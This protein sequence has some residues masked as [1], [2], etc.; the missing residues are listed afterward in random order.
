MWTTNTLLYTVWTWH[1]E[2]I[3]SDQYRWLLWLHTHQ[4]LLRRCQWHRWSFWNAI[5]KLSGFD[6][7]ALG[8]LYPSP[9]LSP[10]QWFLLLIVSRRRFFKILCSVFSRFFLFRHRVSPSQPLPK[11]ASIKAV[12]A[13]QPID[14]LIEYHYYQQLACTM[15]SVKNH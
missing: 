13:P 12:E 8:S 7:K 14:S 3:R 1:W 9:Y 6:S 11:A 5:K 10:R 2:S 15:T 4:L